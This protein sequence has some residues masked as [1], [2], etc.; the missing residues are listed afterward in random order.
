MFR[1]ISTELSLIYSA[2]FAGVLAAIAAAVYLAVDS[3]SR[4][5]VSAE[6]SASSAVFDRLWRLQAAQ[7]ADTAEVVS[8]DFGFRRSVA[9]GDMP[10]MVSAMENLADRADLDA[11]FVVLSDGAL[12]GSGD[13][14]AGVDISGLADTLFENAETSGVMTI[15]GAPYQAVAKP[16]LAPALIGWVVL[17]R[18][19]GVST[20]IEL[21]QFSAIPLKARLYIQTEGGD[22]REIAGQDAAAG[23]LAGA[24]LAERAFTASNKAFFDIPE[25]KSIGGVKML[26]PFGDSPDAALVLEYSLEQNQA[27]Y[28]ELLTAIL[29]I[30][31]VGFCVVLSGSWIISGRVTRPLQSLR[32]AADSLASGKLQR[33][34]VVGRNEIAVLANNFNHMSGEITT[35]EKKIAFLAEH[36]SETGLPNRLV[37]QRRLDSFREQQP[38]DR[39]FT[40]AIGLDRFVQTRGAIG[41]EQSAELVRQ[42]ASR[43]QKVSGELVVGRLATDVL[44]AVFLSDSEAGARELANRLAVEFETP[45]SIGKDRIDAHPSFGIASDARERPAGLSLL[46]C[47]EV[48]IS[49]ARSL[50]NPVAVFEAERYGNPSET[51]SL[52]SS[53]IGGLGRGE[54][55]LAHQ[56][57]LDLATN[58]VLSVESLIRWRHPDRGFIRPDHFIGMAEETGHIR[59]L[60]DWVIDQAIRDQRELRK[61]GY[62]LKFSINISGRVI[63]DAAFARRAIERVRRAGANLCFEITETAVI[64][65]GDRAIDIMRSLSEAGVEISIDDY[66]SGLSSLSYLRMMPAKELK[67]DRMF[68]EDLENSDSDALLVRSTTEL[69]H[70]L[71]MSVTA[72]GIEEPET[73]ELLRAMGVDTIQGYLVGRPMPTHELIEFLA[74][75]GKAVGTA[76]RQ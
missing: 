22:W 76:H 11:A 65:D 1:R 52:M 71:G 49:Q 55:F 36:D 2:L 70:G 72:E 67:I 64:D 12:V 62:D 21:E 45:V 20:L 33:V 8:R 44:G 10:T 53:L 51:L 3:N 18:R 57:K 37:L 30:G 23:S 66:G 69:A 75:R 25:N 39:I 47:A 43:T 31:L 68:V 4:E 73:L 59:P 29:L 38:K 7:L 58:D 24:E 41:Y 19:L 9:T 74:Q 15:D 13:A 28:R 35:R 63:V 14:T 60:T 26:Q 48:A 42:V 50:K 16:V 5:V 27:H 34:D 56:P 46:E 6:M 61:L 17:G 54:L 32:E 40:L